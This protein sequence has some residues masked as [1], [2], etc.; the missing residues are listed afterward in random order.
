M[1]ERRGRDLQAG[2]EQDTR[3]CIV[4]VCTIV[5]R[6]SEVPKVLW[7]EHKSPVPYGL[8]TL[9]IKVGNTGYRTVLGFM[10]EDA[11]GDERRWTHHGMLCLAAVVCVT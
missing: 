5:G 7:L 4:P 2:S 1:E 8:F 11:W 3:N 9:V 6:S 10:G